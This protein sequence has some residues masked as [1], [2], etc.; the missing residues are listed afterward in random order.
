MCL[1]PT[2]PSNYGKEEGTK[3]LLISSQLNRIVEL[4]SRIICFRRK[5]KGTTFEE[6]VNFNGILERKR[7]IPIRIYVSRK[8]EHKRG[9]RFQ[10]LPPYGK[11]KCR[12]TAFQQYHK[13]QQQ[14]HHFHS[15]FGTRKQKLFHLQKLTK[16]FN[17][18]FGRN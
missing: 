14:Q 8:R 3:R 16:K 17:T 12:E 18:Y 1:A 10:V 9:T 6:F 2:T 13:V 11:I 5:K 4:H 7:G 15:H